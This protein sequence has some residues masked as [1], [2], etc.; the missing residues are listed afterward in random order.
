LCGRK[1]PRVPSAPQHNILKVVMLELAGFQV[2]WCASEISPP[3]IKLEWS[4]FLLYSM[5]PE[6]HMFKIGPVAAGN[7]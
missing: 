3:L 5:D 7:R 4:G 1:L 6:G 2:K